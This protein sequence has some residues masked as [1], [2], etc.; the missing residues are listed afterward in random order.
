ME[1]SRSVA[2]SRRDPGRCIYCGAAGPFTDEH[3]I[4]A[5]LGAGDRL[6]L[7]ELV[8]GQ[9]NGAFSKFEV[10]VLRRGDIGLGRLVLQMHSRDR[11]KKTKAPTFEPVSSTLIAEDGRKLEVSLGSRLSA[12]VIPQITQRGPKLELGGTDP[13]KIESFF[14]HLD[15][16]LVDKLILV[17]KKSTGGPSF[18]EAL[19]ILEKTGYALVDTRAVRKPSDFAIWLETAQDSVNGVFPR[20]V[21]RGPTSV[22]VQIPQGD[23]AQAAAFLSL[24]KANL[25]DLKAELLAKPEMFGDQKPLIHVVADSVE[26]EVVRLIAK[27]GFNLLV[28]TLGESLCRREE[29]DALCGFVLKGTPPL[30][31]KVWN[32]S[33]G[34]LP[35]LIRIFAHKHWMMLMSMPNP[36]GGSGLAFACSFYGGPVRTVL[37]VDL[38]P[39]DC[40][41]KVFFSVDY[42]NHTVQQYGLREITKL[43]REA[44]V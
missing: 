44:P 37:L 5:G 27:T 18:T 16:L 6:Q 38:L 41:P 3:A 34:L 39:P 35:Q 2:L 36:E 4:S 31:V 1:D 22:A 24:I 11:G 12:E 10:R 7:H 17:V 29:F 30:A 8:C 9:C 42:Q 33:E 26:E 13:L 21:A 15:L 43:I 19:L 40:E 14:K 32:D 20:V 28:L 25:L 23:V